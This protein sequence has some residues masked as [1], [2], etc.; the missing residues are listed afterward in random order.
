MKTVKIGILG[1]GTIGS[2]VY[3][4]IEQ[5]GDY[6]LHKEGVKLEVKSVF[7][8]SYAMDIPEEKR[9]TNVDALINDKEI[10]IVV[11]VLGGIEPAKTFVTK[12]LRAG[13]TVVS[14]NKMLIASHWPELEKEAKQ[15]NSGL[16][17]EASVAGGI[18]ILRAVSDSLQANTITSVAAIING[19]TNYILTK[20]CDEGGEFDTVLKQAQ[21][22]GYA[23]ADPTSDVDAYD[24]M[25][26]LSILASIAFHTRLPIE[27]IY[28][29]GIRNITRE[30]IQ[31]AQELG[32]D[33]KLLAIAK[34]VG[35]L[36]ELRVHPTL[37]P[38][39]HPLANVKDAFNA[40]L[41][42]GS[43]VDDVM[44]YGR[45][46]GSL[47][48]ASAVLSDVVFASKTQ[49]HKYV[50]FMN[51]E[52]RLSPTLEFNENWECGYF[53]RLKVVDRPGTLAK[54]TSILGEF[55]VSI[56]SV[57]QKGTVGGIATIIFVTHH[58]HE[59]DAQ[60]A[61]SKLSDLEEVHEICNVIRVES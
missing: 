34:R 17:F 16:Y 20:M 5:E 37:I 49:A 1:M 47:P 57:L 58:A 14:A 26:K 43:T 55:G 27:H 31:Y 59:K 32:M 28:R 38:W 15:T 42:H 52:E 48:T 45:G 19:T 41:I 3:K 30:D 61:L 51:E 9:A 7:S 10:S 50:T 6:I 8:R 25:Y 35:E 39:T 33:I 36:V 40:V 21:E 11:E 29:E 22:L 56:S 12:A 53:I 54:I 13:K 2:G 23:E 46:A 18:P 44:F 4:V 24:S 60:L